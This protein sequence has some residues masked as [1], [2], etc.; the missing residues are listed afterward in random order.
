MI[1]PEVLNPAVR[2]YGEIQAFCA[3]L[4]EKAM[5]LNFYG[6]DLVNLKKTSPSKLVKPGDLLFIPKQGVLWRVDYTASGISKKTPIHLK[7][8]PSGNTPLVKMSIAAITVENTIGMFWYKI[9]PNFDTMYLLRD[10]RTF[11]VAKDDIPYEPEPLPALDLKNKNTDGRT[12][13]FRCG[14]GLNMVLYGMSNFSY[15]P[16]C[17]KE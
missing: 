17:E 13:C 15:C 16:K 8:H 1:L 2:T 5:G 12:E 10:A 3:C 7:W 14:N 11:P 9:R 6:P 4:L